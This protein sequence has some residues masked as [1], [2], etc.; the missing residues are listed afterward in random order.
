MPRIITGLREGAPHV[1]RDEAG[2]QDGCRVVCRTCCGGPSDGGV[3]PSQRLAFQYL[4]AEARRSPRPATALS[5]ET[6]AEVYVRADLSLRGGRVRMSLTS[7]CEVRSEPAAVVVGPT[8]LSQR[9]AVIITDG[10]FVY[11]LCRED[12][13][14]GSIHWAFPSHKVEVDNS[15]KDAA[16]KA[17]DLW[18]GSAVRKG[19]SPDAVDSIFA[20][21][22]TLSRKMHLAIDGMEPLGEFEGIVYFVCTI[23]GMWDHRGDFVAARREDTI[24]SFRLTDQ[25]KKQ[26]SGFNIAKPSWIRDGVSS[27][28]ILAA[29]L[30][31]KQWLL[32]CK[33]TAEE[34]YQQPPKQKRKNASASVALAADSANGAGLPADAEQDFDAAIADADGRLIEAATLLHFA[35]ITEGDVATAGG[36]HLPRDED[37]DATGAP[38]KFHIPTPSEV[39]EEQ[40][41]HPAL[42]PIVLALLGEPTEESGAPQ[43]S[44]LEHA[45]FIKE[46]K[47]HK[48]QEDTGVLLR[49]CDAG[50]PGPD[51]EPASVAGFRIV[52]P[53]KFHSYALTAYHDR[54]G[55]LGGKKCFSLL[56]RRYYWGSVSEMRSRM[57]EHIKGCPVCRRC[58]VSRHR[59]GEGTVATNG[60][61]AFDI[62]SA[63][64][65]KVG[66]ESRVDATDE[67]IVGV[68]A[69]NDDDDEEYT[70]VPFFDGT[71]TFA[72]QFT[73]LVV[74]APVKGAPTAQVVARLLMREVIRH[75]G[76]PRQLR[77]DL[78]SSF[79]AAA[80]KALYEAF[81]IQMQAS[82]AYHHA[83]V[84]LV[85]R[86]HSCLK[87]L[88]LTHRVASGQ[89]QW[90]LIFAN[91]G[92]G[93]Q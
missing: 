47:L 16:I 88:L 7:L 34:P 14:A 60:E 5:A 67:R 45:A 79:V 26:Y 17:V 59:V 84:G 77:S 72:D 57:Y 4:A 52:L 56:Y 85:E 80:V 63:D 22:P 20:L 92:A 24:A 54:V 30:A 37:V 40:R 2:V 74:C 68:P 48:L 43:P 1:V 86:W 38:P 29:A 58:K 83:T 10:E 55:H 71:I 15:P 65:F 23:D 70:E 78:G 8:L 19:G 21:C 35:A 73:R 89:D 64:Y 87:S 46:L 81:G 66:R 49:W 12:G 28:D 9:A 3:A 11:L 50:S 91:D 61:H 27:G 93:L 62:V 41:Q 25:Q 53:P 44:S 82:T 42:R 75:Y 32:K 36:L 18:A 76:T 13:E 69:D 6:S 90:H 33:F 51:D 39:A 31:E